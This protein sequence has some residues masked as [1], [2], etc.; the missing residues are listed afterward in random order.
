[1]RRWILAALLVVGLLAAPLLSG[2]AA[3][4]DVGVTLIAKNVNWHVGMETAPS[5]PTVTVA[6]GDVLRL[7][8]VNNDTM[9]H[10]FTLPHFSVNRTFAAGATIFVNITTTSADKGRWQFYC[11]IA[12]HTTGS[13]PNRDGMVGW[14]QVGV[15]V[16]L[17]AENNLWKVGT[18]TKP[19]ITVD[20]GDVLMLRI[21]NLDAFPHTFTIA[22]FGINEPMP[23]SS[24]IFVNITTSS[25]DNGK[26]QFYC[27]I[28]GHASG[29]GEN[30]DGMVGWV[31]VGA[32]TTPPPTPGFEIVLM[33]AALVAVAALTRV[34]SRRRK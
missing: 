14:V 15:S 2:P 16:T 9:A 19:T 20:P 31:Q 17:V 4:A 7:R 3:A 12:G 5:K 21:E 33:V 25:A 29:T 11:A 32:P 18:T 8:V 22:H 28:A 24:T 1:M 13:D 27:A 34:A 30:R 6:A 23:A 10:T 26:W